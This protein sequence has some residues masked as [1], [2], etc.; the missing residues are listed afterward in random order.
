[1]GEAYPAPPV[2]NV[3]IRIR[4]FDLSWKSLKASLR[5]AAGIA[6]STRKYASPELFKAW[7]TISNVFRQEEKMMLYIH[8][9][10]GHPRREKWETDHLP[11]R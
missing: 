5:A 3:M 7:A 9:G 4:Y 1:M 8:L 2:P 6:P 11:P 10:L